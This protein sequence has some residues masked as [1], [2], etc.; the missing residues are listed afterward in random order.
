MSGQKLRLNI[1]I[2]LASLFIWG[3]FAGAVYLISE[4]SGGGL[5][6][7][8]DRWSALLTSSAAVWLLIVAVPSLGLVRRRHSPSD[9]SKQADPLTGLL[10][11]SAMEDA[12]TSYFRQAALNEH[13]LVSMD[14]RA[15][16]RF[17][18]MYGHET[19]DTLLKAVGNCINANYRCGARLN[20]DLFLFV[21]KNSGHLAQKIEETILRAI[22]GEL[23]EHYTQ[24]FSLKFGIYPLLQDRLAFREAYDGSLLALKSAKA[25]PKKREVVYDLAMLKEDKMNKFI[26]VNMHSAL[27]G[28]EFL[29]YMQPKFRASDSS[30]C[31]GEALI[32]W[33]SGQMGFLAPFQFIPM[34]ENNGF[35]AETD[36]YMME[37]IMQ[38]Q[39]RYLQLG[40]KVLPISVNQSGVTI[41]FPNY[42][43]RL[44][45]LVG[46]YPL[47][48]RLIEI[49]ITESILTENYDSVVNLVG[50]LKEMGF[51]VAMDDFGTGYSSL[52]TLRE[53]PVDV[54]KIDK[55]F[56]RESD[57]SQRGRKIIQS[58]INMSR[59]LS[60]ETVCE[61]VESGMQLDF[62]RGGG[63]DMVQGFFLARPMPY[64]EYER[65]FLT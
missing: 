5:L 58:V 46:R 28:G 24:M 51:T 30:C 12:M 26:E 55:E 32:R 17:N 29:L 45:G 39:Q 1:L 48:P 64:E 10:S 3:G 61:G 19:G 11:V 38:H 57:T 31:G 8:P 15:F 53:I 6:I 62:L 49:E 18:V 22:A 65:R 20:S 50:K 2:T 63:C 21:V 52:N 16:R 14:I 43:E 27:R 36:L 7:N 60:I 56:L 40:R 44:T 25:S 37:K 35:I 54:L 47:P 23:G 34:F 4:K 41:S 13:C 9:F 33:Q 42:L 59:E